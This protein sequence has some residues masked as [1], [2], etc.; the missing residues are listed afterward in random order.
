MYSSDV[1]KQQRISIAC[2]IHVRYVENILEKGP[3][4]L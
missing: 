1:I 2:R 3:I 4:N